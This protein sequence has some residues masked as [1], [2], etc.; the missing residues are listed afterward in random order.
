MAKVTAPFLSLSARGSVA[1]TLTA[2][3]WKGIKTMRQKSNPANPNTAAQQTQRSHFARLVE[4][5][6][7]GDKTPDVNPSWELAAAVS[8]KPLTAL[9]AF[10]KAAMDQIKL[11]NQGITARKVPDEFEGSTIYGSCE[12]VAIDGTTLTNLGSRVFKVV[13]GFSPIRMTQSATCTIEDNTSV[14]SNGIDTGATENCKYYMQFFEKVG[15]RWL[16]ITGIAEVM[17]YVE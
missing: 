6:K 8:G 2:S 15:S 12:C 9:N 13:G 16:P 14:E 5:W 10:T 3:K 17:I 4:F 7:T 11:T 1:N